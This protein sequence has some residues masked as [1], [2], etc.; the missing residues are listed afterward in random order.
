MPWPLTSPGHHQKLTMQDKLGI[1]FNEKALQWYHNERHGVSN[2]RR[3][4]CLLN[5]L[6][7]RTSKKTSKLRFTGLCEGNSLVAGGFPLQRVSKAENVLIWWRHLDDCIYSSFSRKMSLSPA[8]CRFQHSCFLPQDVAFSIHLS[9]N[10]FTAR[11]LSTTVVSP[12]RKW[13]PWVDISSPQPASA[14]FFAKCPLRACALYIPSL[15]NWQ[16]TEVDGRAVK[17]V[18]RTVV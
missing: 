15:N 2:H 11:P 1:V 12:P 16:L 9:D 18:R 5:R 3:L 10:R 13:A 7:R 14:R 17:W 6:F 8:R 4:N